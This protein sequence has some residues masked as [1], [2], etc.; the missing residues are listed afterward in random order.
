VPARVIGSP[1][2]DAN[3]AWSPD[4]RRLAFISDRAGTLD[5]WVVGVQG[6]QVIGDP[7]RLTELPE[8]ELHP[9][10]SPRGDAVAFVVNG[11]E[12]SEVY[13][14]DTQGRRRPR[15]V[16]TGAHAAFTTYARDPAY[17]LVSGRWD[18]ASLE[19]R[20]VRIED[21]ASESIDPPLVLGGEAALGSFALSPNGGLLA[22]LQQRTRGGIWVL[23]AREGC[24]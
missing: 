6:G 9:A 12:S 5:V 11:P 4:G 17:L 24:F 8:S 7:A 3:P 1:G 20:R 22:C 16:T 14:V 21:G 15:K 2:V 23:E 13:V 19:V 18:G 10:W